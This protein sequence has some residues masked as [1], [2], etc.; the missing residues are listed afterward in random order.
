MAGTWSHSICDLCW[1]EYNPEREPFRLKNQY[2]EDE[3]CCFC[4][5]QHR[6]GIYIRR[7]PK[8]LTCE[9]VR[10]VHDKKIM[11]EE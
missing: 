3:R 8:E 7:D 4:T 10:G 1:N 5:N 9:G 11:Q 6:S 2:R